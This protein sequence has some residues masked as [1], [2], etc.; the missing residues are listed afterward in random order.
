MSVQLVLTCVIT[1]AR[2]HQ[3]LTPAA[4]DLATPSVKMAAP[5]LVCI[6]AYSIKTDVSLSHADFIADI[7]ECF[8]GTDNCDQNCRNTAGSFV[9]TCNTG[10]T[11]NSDNHT[12][13]GI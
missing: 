12:C 5:V 2:T 13:D 11:L 8:M 4:A 6:C 9:C 1:T 3:A 10:Y 7:N